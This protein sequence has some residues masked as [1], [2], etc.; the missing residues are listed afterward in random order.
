MDLC[1][2]RYRA[3]RA[4][5]RADVDE[6]HE[7]GRSGDPAFE[8]VRA[9]RFLTHRVERE[10]VHQ[11]RDRKAIEIA[12]HAD[13]QP[14]G[15]DSGALIHRSRASNRSSASRSSLH[16]ILSYAWPNVNQP[17]SSCSSASMRMIAVPGSSATKPTSDAMIGPAWRAARYC[18]S[19][20]NDC[21]RS[22]GSG[23]PGL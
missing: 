1:A 15:T 11:L 8:N 18:D 10:V 7:G 4:A 19:I 9:S 6:D 23:S 12:G 22:S 14:C 17:Y 16:R 2:S 21:S 5:S 13:L 20:M 3:E